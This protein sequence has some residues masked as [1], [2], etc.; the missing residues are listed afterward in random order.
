M[1]AEENFPLSFLLPPGE[2]SRSSWSPPKA[3]RSALT[4]SQKQGLTF[5]K[6]IGLELSSWTRQNAEHYTLHKQLAL[7]GPEGSEYEGVHIPDFILESKTGSISFLIE[8]KRTFTLKG[9]AQ[10]IRYAPVVSSALGIRLVLIQAVQYLE[11]HMLKHNYKLALGRGAWKEL[12]G[13]K[14]QGPAVW[15]IPVPDRLDLLDDSYPV[16]RASGP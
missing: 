14:T 6:K 16:V 15:H 3:K 1:S 10:L 13:L 4:H 9:I 12:I 7:A 11:P 2:A 8:T 5:E